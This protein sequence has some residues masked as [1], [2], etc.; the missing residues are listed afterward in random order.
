M[1]K[2]GFGLMRLPITDSSNPCSI[3]QLQVN[4]M[5]DYFLEHG[6]TYFD[7][8]YP[9]HQGVS[10]IAARKSLVERYPRESFLLADKM[11]VWMVTSHEDYQ[12]FFDEQLKRCGVEYF[13]YYLLHTMGEKNYSLTLKYDGFTFMK[14]LKAEGKVKHIGMSFHDKAVVLDQILTEHPELEFVQLQIN[15]ID[16]ENES[17][18]SR[19]CYEV[20]VKH[21]KPVIVMEPVKG[22]SLTNLPNEAEMLFKTYHSELSLASWAIRYAASLEH[23]FMVLSGMSNFEQIQDNVEYM[24]NFNPLNEEE[25]KIIEKVTKMIINGVAIPCTSCQYC[26]DGCPKNI[27]IPNFFSLYNNQKEFGLK[28]LHTNYYMN[29][30]E[31]YGK[32]SDCIGCK[33]C[34]VHCP[35]HIKIAEQIQKVAQVF[36]A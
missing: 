17:I 18:E 10:E 23:V 35:Q 2:L 36:E 13:D 28:P 7:T 8:A 27:P 4:K 12:K 25:R 11:P 1:K 22:G 6:F 3:D 16:W 19:K 9:Y 15:Y 24:E 32:A 33:Q 30:I 29:L 21:N 14:Q 31:K 5:I 34:E 26:V 20:A